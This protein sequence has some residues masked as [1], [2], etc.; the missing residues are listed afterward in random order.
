[1]FTKTT[2][3]FLSLLVVTTFLF[4]FSKPVYQTNFSGTW[5]INQG[6]SELGQFGGRGVAT[7]IVVDQKADGVTTNKTTAGFN[8]GG[9]MVT[10]EALTNDGKEVETSVFNGNGKRKAT[11]K[12]D[13]DGNAFT[14]TYSISFGQGELTGNEKWSMSADG[15]QM[16]VT[17]TGNFGGNEF[18]TKA[19]YDKQ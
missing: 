15:K 5:A 13:A 4:S 19:V 18:V 8:G 16:T 3:K 12:W 9:D 11:L 1:M 10:A 14:I 2:K 7:K 17:N 6:K